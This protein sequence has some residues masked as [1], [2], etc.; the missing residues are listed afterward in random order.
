V[1][2]TQRLPGAH[3]SEPRLETVPPDPGRRIKWEIDADGAARV[4]QYLN[5]RMSHTDGC[6]LAWLGGEIDVAATADCR[7]FLLAA[8]G[9]GRGRLVVDVTDVRFIDASGLG[10]LVFVAK[11]AARDGGWLRL[12]GANPMLRRMMGIISLSAVLPV[13]ATVRDAA[14]A[15]GAAVPRPRQG[16]DR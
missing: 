14:E 15:P 4:S 5:M 13:Y 7:T 6:A 8:L 2:L 16:S 9:E 1:N 3:E 11:A 10:V 12:V